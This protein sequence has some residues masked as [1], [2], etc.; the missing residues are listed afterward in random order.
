MKTVVA[1]NEQ[2]P[3]FHPQLWGKGVLV[4]AHAHVRTHASITHKH[5]SKAEETDGLNLPT[6]VSDEGK[7]FH[8][9][10]QECTHTISEMHCTE[11]PITLSQ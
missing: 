10:R 4:H 5:T 3:G 1:N 8:A 9:F 7:C 2:S 11:S 6:L